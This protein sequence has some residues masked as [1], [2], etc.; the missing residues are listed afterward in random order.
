[1]MLR[2]HR[3]C[4]LSIAHRLRPI[5]SSTESSQ[6]AQMDESQ[7]SMRRHIQSQPT[8]FLPAGDELH[9]LAVAVIAPFLPY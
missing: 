1:M 4:S 8:P 9:G 6:I 5:S 2:M 7:R 3:E